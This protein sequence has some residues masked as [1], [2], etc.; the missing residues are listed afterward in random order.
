MAEKVGEK[1]RHLPYILLLCLVA[2]LGTMIVSPIQPEIATALGVTTA[3]MSFSLS[4]YFIPSIFLAPIYG[5][6]SDKY[7]RLPVMI[8]T[9][10]I[11]GLS[12]LG[13][14]FVTNFNSFII[15]RVFQG[16]ANA[17]YIVFAAVLAGDLYSGPKL[18][19]AM[20]AITAAGGVGMIIGLNIGSFLSVLGWQIP[21]LFFL[22]TIPVAVL[23]TYGLRD[24]KV[25]KKKEIYIKTDEGKVRKTRIRDFATIGLVLVFVATF[26]QPF[27][28][29]SAFLNYLPFLMVS[30]G[31]ERT[32]K[33]LFMTCMWLG[34]L[35]SGL[36]F[37]KLCNRIEIKKLLMIAYL[38][39]AI[40]LFSL[41]LVSNQFQLVGVLFIYG[42][43][44]GII[45]ASIKTLLLTLCPPNAKGTF[46]SFQQG[47]RSVGRTA[48]PAI[49]ALLGSMFV[50]YTNLSIIYWT[51]AGF[52]T[53]AALVVLIT[54]SE[55]L[56]SCHK[57]LNFVDKETE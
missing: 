9:L 43:G 14:F 5:A 33:G 38:V 54:P 51:I 56:K 8:P 52:T 3:D 12:G 7:G 47:I 11:F 36:L 32:F 53:I 28:N 49:F 42:L 41:G 30:I 44:F 26:Y 34:T 21:F 13:I 27:Q 18:K 29:S 22:F 45:G 31:I 39:N 4:L 19:S 15:L 2:E 16:I 55:K 37:G 6:I 46:V 20:G 40:S 25:K 57:Q 10:I 23:L 48:G 24:V 17:G 50:I 35:S 1:D